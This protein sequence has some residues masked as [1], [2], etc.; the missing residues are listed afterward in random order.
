MAAGAGSLAGA[1]ALLTV[2]GTSG[3]LLLWRPRSRAT[4]WPGASVTWAELVPLGAPAYS[5]IEPSPSRLFGSAAICLK[6]LNSS[7]S[8]TPGSSRTNVGPPACS[9]VTFET[10]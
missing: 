7:A 3:G 6:C 5:T 2:K 8:V 1:V 9:L 10:T 4:Y